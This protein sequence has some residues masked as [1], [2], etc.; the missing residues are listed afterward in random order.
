[1]EFTVSLRVRY[2]RKRVANIIRFRKV[3]ELLR[4][5]E[6]KKCFDCPTKVT[7]RNEKNKMMTN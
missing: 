2:K 5:P 4:L 7:K 3:R 1:M 6:N